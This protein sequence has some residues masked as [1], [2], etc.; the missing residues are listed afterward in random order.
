MAAVVD[1]ELSQQWEATPFY[2]FLMIDESTHIFTDQTLIMYI[3][4]VCVQ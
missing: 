4:V 1:E 3:Y 2:S